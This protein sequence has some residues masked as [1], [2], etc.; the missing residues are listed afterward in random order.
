MNL[1]F[2][3]LPGSR[4]QLASEPKQLRNFLS[5]DSTWN[6]NSQTLGDVG[7]DLFGLPGA[8]DWP[9][10]TESDSISSLAGVALSARLLPRP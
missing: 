9:R 10:K 4:I 1:Y 8:E 6:L 3:I 2:F 5:K 7:G